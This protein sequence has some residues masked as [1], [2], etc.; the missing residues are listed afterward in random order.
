MRVLLTLGEPHVIQSVVQ[1]RR[2]MW[3]ALRQRKI[4][5]GL[6]RGAVPLP[7]TRCSVL[8]S[9]VIATLTSAW[10]A[11]TGAGAQCPCRNAAIC[12]SFCVLSATHAEQWFNAA[13]LRIHLV[14]LFSKRRNL[15]CACHLSTKSKREP[16]GLP[17]SHHLWRNDAQRDVHQAS[18]PS[19]FDK[20]T[21]SSIRAQG[22][23]LS[24]V[25]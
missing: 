22:R 6:V 8:Q 11:Y 21:T 9:P 7:R 23:K 14:L 2:R 20:G 12:Y 10:G 25:V 3:H 19:S 24:I 17:P 16:I 13:S 18:A 5:A 15:C 1:I 4:L